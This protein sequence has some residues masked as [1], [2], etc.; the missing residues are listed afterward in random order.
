MAHYQQGP[1]ECIDA[2]ESAFGAQYLAIF[3]RRDTPPR[4]RLAWLAHRHSAAPKGVRA[5]RCARKRHVQG[6]FW[7]RALQSA[8][9][10]LLL[11]ADAIRIVR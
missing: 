6:L 4:W 10:L 7:G 2:M 11:L 5:V 8:V 3:C 1:I 9:I